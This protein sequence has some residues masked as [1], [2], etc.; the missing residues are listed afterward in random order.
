MVGVANLGYQWATAEVQSV[1]YC[2]R[3]AAA[4]QNARVSRTADAGRRHIILC[5]S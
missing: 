4:A 2:R 1:Q 5:V 3:T